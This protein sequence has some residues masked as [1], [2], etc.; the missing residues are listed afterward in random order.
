MQKS[1]ELVNPGTTPETD[2]SDGAGDR[3]RRAGRNVPLQS[4]VIGGLV[5]V[6]VVALAVLGWQLRS[7]THELDQLH[8]A[9]ASTQ[10]AE[11][12]A[13]DYATG[14]AEM[15]FRDLPAW[16]TRLTAGTSP[17]LSNRL[18]Q[19]ATSMEQ[20]IA[21]LQWTSTAQPISAKA[22]PGPDG[23]YSVDCF[24]SV[25]TK[26]SQAPDG[27]QSTATYKMTVD[28]GNEWKITEISG[29]DSALDGDTAPR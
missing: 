11:R 9:A 3:E 10:Q 6:L 22:E 18:T 23:T 24:V 26:N 2:H 12:I 29:I 13:L 15:D 28:S 25:L 27:L 17:E 5:A 19:A 16:R 20:I 14:A 7:T 8:D 4:V 21:P 1:M